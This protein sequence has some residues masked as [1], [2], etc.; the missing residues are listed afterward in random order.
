MLRAAALL[1]L[2]SPVFGQPANADT[3]LAAVAANFAGAATAL[4]ADFKTRS[5]HDITLTTGSTGKLY[6]QIIAGAPFDVLLS[7]DAAIPAQ[8]QAAGHGLAF[9]YAYGV[10]TL[11]APNRTTTDATTLLQSTETRHIAIANPDLA[12]YGAAAK[13]AL[14]AMGIYD[15]IADK[16]VMGQNIGQAFAL[17][18]SG[19]A[20]AGFIAKSALP[21]DATGF[22]WDV[23]PALYP[24]I[25]QDAILLTYGADNAA[26]KGFLDYLQ[27][28]NA[29]AIIAQ[30]GY[31][32][33]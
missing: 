14:T 12:P 16:I 22:I 19:A 30:F 24:P 15:K 31:G 11:W 13:A 10:L 2:A 25:Q 3:A 6:A 28:P 5:G 1:L 27:S 26:A 4:A 20:D 17:T 9:P 29:H 33:P 23:P 8:L 7:A 32:L 21:A 18:S